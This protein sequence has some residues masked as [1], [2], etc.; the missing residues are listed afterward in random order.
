MA[1]RSRNLRFLSRALVVLVAT[2][3]FQ[4]AAGCNS[5]G[6][7][8][9]GPCTGS[10]CTCEQDPNQPLCKGFN[11]RPETGADLP[12]GSFQFDAAKNAAPD[13]ADAADGADGGVGD[14]SDDAG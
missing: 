4:A 10:A 14:A 7:T 5:A 13:A 9:S 11:D 12:D 1:V 6:Y 8:D 2:L 3:G